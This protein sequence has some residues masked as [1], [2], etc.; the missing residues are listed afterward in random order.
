MLLTAG[1]ILR[2]RYRILSPLGQ[3]G[4]GAVYR[5]YDAALDREVA[6][7]QLRPDLGE[8]DEELEQTRQQ[9]QR[10]ARILATLSHPNLPRV[11]DYFDQ[12]HDQF[13]VM[14]FVEGQSLSEIVKA[15]DQGL[16]ENQ[17]LDWAD[18]LLSALE[19]IHQHK[20]IHRDVKPANI[21]LTSDGR[22]FLVDFGLAKALDPTHPQTASIMR[23][24]GTAE[25]APPEQ[26]DTGLG[27]TDAR[28]D[29]YSLGATLYHLLAGRAPATATQRMA[30]PDKFKP[31]DTQGVAIS[32]QVQRVIARAME[33]TRNSRFAT[34]SDMQT[35]LR[36]ARANQQPIELGTTN[37]LAGEAPAV[38]APTRETA[39]TRWYVIGGLIVVVLIALFIIM[40]TPMSSDATPTAAPTVAV[41][42]KADVRIVTLSG[43]TIPEYVVIQ[44]YG[45]VTQTMTGWRL[46]SQI[47]PQTF[48]FPA[49]YELAPNA[50]VRIESYNGAVNN[51]PATLLWT[52][53]PI[54]LN[55]GDKAILYDDQGKQVSEQCY[56][57]GCP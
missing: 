29:I 33:L 27:H 53:D 24:R 9:F 32:P 10:E 52:P 54:W 36:L 13:L 7:K 3:G 37:R 48:N 6:I 42:A 34:A 28:S 41:P 16:D 17:V 43:K 30:D 19:Y 51:P 38:T 1:Q 2:D 26:Y 8:S 22:I 31:L 18:Q 25:Y 12:D 15:T 57:N 11:T 45:G 5:A 47:G 39:R 46:L 44:N 14:D 20:I 40:R 35:A 23:G 50:S 4:M 55:A 49:G 56:D 21:R